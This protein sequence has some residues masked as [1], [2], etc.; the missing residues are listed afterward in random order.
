MSNEFVPSQEFV[1]AHKA[2]VEIDG[3][4]VFS[5]KV[6]TIE[7]KGLQRKNK[8]LS[9]IPEDNE[10][11]SKITANKQHFSELRH[12][13]L[14]LTNACN[15]SCKYCYEQ[16]NRDY[17]RFT[18]ESL[19]KVY[20]FLIS[21][22][23]IDGKMLQFFGG[24]P[25]IQKDLILKF[26]KENKKVLADNINKCR[27]SI[28]TNGLLLTDEF[29]EEYFA[30]EFVAMLISLDTDDASI[31][32]R[33]ISQEDIDG[34]IAQLGKIPNY[35][36]E[37]KHVCI[38]CTISRET[39]GRLESF[40][41]KIYKN[42]IRN[43][44]IHPLT[45]SSYQ[46]EIIWTDEQW[47]TLE[48][49]IVKLFEK[50]P[51]LVIQ[52][53]EGV[54]TRKQSNCMVGSD[55]I[56]VDGSGDYAGCYFF[57]NQKAAL[58]Q[59]V[60]GNIFNDEIFTDRYKA[61]QKEYDNMFDVDEQC[62]TCDLKGYCYQCP[63]GNLSTGEKKMFRSDKMC[64]K[65]V[66]LYNNLQQHIITRGFTK[67]YN[68]ITKSYI[69]ASNIDNARLRMSV[70][71]LY[72]YITT[73]HMKHEMADEVVNHFL[74]DEKNKGFN[75]SINNLPIKDDFLYKYLLGF[76]CDA[77]EKRVDYIS[78]PIKFASAEEF[79]DFINK[80]KSRLANEYECAIVL[81]KAVGVDM[82]NHSNFNDREIYDNNG[83]ECYSA[84][85]FALIHIIIFDKRR[86]L[87]S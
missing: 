72:K 51:E 7:T 4:K 58:S 13:N 45:M 49:T 67:K 38:R 69:S 63:A 23:N 30:N 59:T 64:K 46:G 44:V 83:T 16:H 33:E 57:T 82:H 19:K 66:T 34:I 77:V 81:N 85:Y 41:D 80:N 65:I 43:I 39:V 11:I 29:I 25:L 20:D 15:L 14:I 42:G 53:S 5:I 37:N 2:S 74:E 9:V 78:N 62:Q 22:N 70:H 56:A 54:G 31:D 68:S 60:L 47:R 84:M 87:K 8:M 21:A 50:Y 61:F 32:H 27:I 1:D 40:V 73:E 52:F 55:M 6:Q 28:V 26:I 10:T 17:G 35:H 79:I 18:T 36:K 75:Q 86:G 71:L 24:E 12:V 3:K 76:I 48:Y